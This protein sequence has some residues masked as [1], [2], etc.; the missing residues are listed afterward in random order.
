M[1]VMK[2]IFMNLMIHLLKMLEMIIIKNS[3]IQEKV[4]IF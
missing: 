3:L 1:I 4:L 2:I